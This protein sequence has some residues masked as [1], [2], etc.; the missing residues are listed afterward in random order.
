MRRD[1]GGSD[2][3][4]G[5]AGNKARQDQRA[6]HKDQDSVKGRPNRL[7][8]RRNS[9][10]RAAWRCRATSAPR[11]LLDMS[12]VLSVAFT[13]SI[14]ANTRTCP[15]A[16]RPPRRAQPHAHHAHHAPSRRHAHH[17]GQEE[18]R[19]LSR[20]HSQLPPSHS[21][22]LAPLSTQT[23]RP[24]PCTSGPDPF[25]PDPWITEPWNPGLNAGP[26]AGPWTLR[27][28]L[29]AGLWSLE[30]RHSDASAGRGLQASSG[31]AL[32]ASPWPDPS[33]S[34]FP[35]VGARHARSAPE[36]A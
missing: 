6:W 15:P 21:L 23:P 34:P 4:N 22:A 29:A 18:P 35:L 14:A 11:E 3:I 5:S 28:P 10:G 8:G 31:R 24:A 19:R 26:Y 9:H 25:H 32:T 36:M 7:T 20:H 17:A 30:V 27:W 16:P 1:H 33:P 12:T 13:R 2:K